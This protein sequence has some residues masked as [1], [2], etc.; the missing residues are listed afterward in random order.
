MNLLRD[1]SLLVQYV[2][3]ELLHSHF[4]CHLTCFVGVFDTQERVLSYVTAGHLPLPILV[5]GGRARYLEGK[6]KPVGILRITS[7]TYF[8][9]RLP[10][11]LILLCFPMAFWIPCLRKAY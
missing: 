7:G 10:M 4:G 3:K 9:S 11:A 8:M 2:N 5:E 6:G 1:P